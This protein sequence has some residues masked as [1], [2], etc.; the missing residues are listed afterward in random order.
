MAN[1]ACISI[2]IN[3]YQFFQPLGYGS[4]DA[5]AI[6][7]FFVDAA[8]WSPSQCLLLADTSPTI[9]DRSTY[10]DRQNIESWLNDWCKNTLVAGDQ[11]W[12]FF[13]GHGISTG[14]EDYLVPIDGKADDL[15]NTCI[16][17]RQLYQQLQSTGVNVL[18]FLDA[19]RACGISLGE[20]IGAI[21]AQLA[22][23]HQIPTFLSCQSHE[24]SHEA[25]G[26]GH[27]LF[28]TSL[29][30]ALNY[31]PDLNIEILNE[32]ISSRLPELSE[33]HWKPLQTLVTIVP[34]GISPYR[35]V[36]SSTTQTSISS[37]PFPKFGDSP[38]TLPQLDYSTG[39]TP[40]S[41][42]PSATNLNISPI[43]AISRITPIEPERPKSHVLAIGFLLMLLIGAGGGIYAFQS[44]SPTVDRSNNQ[45]TQ[46][47]K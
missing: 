7:Q 25:A 43:R 16:S 20:G 10:P 39:F 11:L 42:T 19:N 12:L 31:H 37:L 15:L 13:S 27:G 18:V 41:I 28:T 5:V 33:H 26:L 34:D 30:E 1:Q 21:A 6:H 23:K 46:P 22:Q 32:Y 4:E 36:F 8:G 35:P 29:L 17:L 45:P 2:G 9:D 3:Q 38:P 24:F 47:N 40:P 44:L 14:G